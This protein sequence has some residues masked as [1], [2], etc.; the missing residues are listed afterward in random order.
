MEIV[1]RGFPSSLSA[2]GE[3]PRFSVNLSEVRKAK[4]VS[5]IRI[6]MEF[7]LAFLHKNKDSIFCATTIPFPK[8]AICDTGRNDLSF[9]GR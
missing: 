3:N 9:R 5:L 4:N 8:A 1:K 2:D 7:K 6:A